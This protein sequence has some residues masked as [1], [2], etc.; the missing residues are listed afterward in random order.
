MMNLFKFLLN[1]N[2]LEGT[3]IE[4]YIESVVKE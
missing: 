4:K 3:V 2:D 1:Q